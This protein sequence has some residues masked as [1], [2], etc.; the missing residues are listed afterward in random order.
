MLLIDGKRYSNSGEL[1]AQ[2]YTE[3][4]PN[5]NVIEIEDCRHYR[6]C[7]QPHIVQE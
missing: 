3:L 4:I 2:K 6:L 5:P 7:E 1:I